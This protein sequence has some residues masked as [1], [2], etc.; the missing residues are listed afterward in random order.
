MKEN[1]T[2]CKFIY[3][4]AGYDKEKCAILKALQ[5]VA[6]HARLGVFAVAH[7][8]TVARQKKLKA[9]YVYT[10]ENEEHL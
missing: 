3:I 1:I 7:H 10:S 8:G 9:S 5:S 4:W 6:L 2:T